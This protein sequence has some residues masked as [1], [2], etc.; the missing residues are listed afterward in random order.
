MTTTPPVY[1]LLYRSQAAVEVTDGVV[2]DILTTSLRNNARLDVTGLLLYVSPS[3][4]PLPAER[5]LGAG[6]FVQWLEG[7]GAA[8]RGLYYDQ[9]E[10]DP[11]HRGCTVVAEGPSRDLLGRDVRLFPRW[12]M[13]LERP[14]ALLETLDAFLT[15]YRRFAAE[16]RL[17]LPLTA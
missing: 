17:P 2:L 3:T 12:S 9:I 1:A 11:R 8:V 14:P 7:P 15:Y 5:G 10:P 13:A 6:R 4:A 16:N